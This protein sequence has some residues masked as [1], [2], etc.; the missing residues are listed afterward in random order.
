MNKPLIPEVPAEPE[1]GGAANHNSRPQPASAKTRAAIR[2]ALAALT[3][4]RDLASEN[5]EP[6]EA[7]GAASDLTAK[8][9][10]L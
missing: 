7:L 5:S 2:K 6:S 8:K 10:A 4:A 9:S 3:T 1:L